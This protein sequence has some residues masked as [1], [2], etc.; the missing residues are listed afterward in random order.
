MKDISLFEKKIGVSFSRK[1]L[2]ETAFTHR[3]YIN[4][5]PDITTGHNERLEFLGDAVLELIIT[6]YLFDKYPDRPEGDLTAYRSALVNTISL[7]ESSEILEVNDYLMLSKGESKDDGRARQ[8]ILANAFEAIIGAIYLDLGYDAA[9]KFIS[10]TLYGKIDSIVAEG[11]WRD[12]KSWVQEKA[13]EEVGVTPSYTVIDEHGPDHDKS[14][15]SG[16]YLGE[17]LIAKGKGKS[18]QEAE[19]DAAKQSLIA[20]GWNK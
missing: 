3:S 19:Q 20:K 12:A 5:N 10:E 1:G 11:S 9:E 13:Q 15:T 17:D 4:E 2:L 7:A 6:R 16:L 18:K 8:H 14:F